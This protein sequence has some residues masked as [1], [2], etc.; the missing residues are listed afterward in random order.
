[1]IDIKTTILHGLFICIPFSIFVAATFIGNARLWLHSLPRDIQQAAIAKTTK[2]EKLT[3]FV[4]LPIFLLIL[5]GLSVVSTVYAA[6]IT[7]PTPAF[8]GILVHL[9]LLWII[10]HAWDLLIID[11]VAMVMIDPR[12]PPIAGTE[13]IAG[14]KNYTFHVKSFFEATMKSAA[15]VVPASA[16]IYYVM[17]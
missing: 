4:L 1:M 8:Y 15:F 17:S 11:A 9:Y 12:H 2:E 3:R 6:G 7:T 10:V 16:V 14:W 13:N 5:P